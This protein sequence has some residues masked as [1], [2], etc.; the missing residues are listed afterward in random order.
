MV[1]IKT[2]I[3]YEKSFSYSTVISPRCMRERVTVV[4]LSVLA[5]ALTFQV[6]TT[7][8][9]LVL[10]GLFTTLSSDVLGRFC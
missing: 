7:D 4:C 2:H 10:D 3:N 1:G 9:N 8:F 5:L 6:C